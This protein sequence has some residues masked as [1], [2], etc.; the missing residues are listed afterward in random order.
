MSN[1]NEKS[2]AK[3]SAKRL[4]EQQRTEFICK[5][6]KPNP[7]SKRSLAREYGVSEKAIRKT[8]EN[9]VAIEQ[10]SSLMSVETKAK[11]FCASVG[12]FSE[13]EDKLYIWIETVH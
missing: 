4:N 1:S 8:W 5:L 6:R 13:L 7:P 3:H 10:R 12:H 9:R 11:T 2:T